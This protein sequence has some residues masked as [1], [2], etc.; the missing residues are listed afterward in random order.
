MEEATQREHIK[1]KFDQNN[2][3]F[4]VKKPEETL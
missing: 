4:I 1:V 2:K 3:I